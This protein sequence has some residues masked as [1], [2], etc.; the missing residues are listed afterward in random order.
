[1]N[2]ASPNWTA[3]DRIFN[4]PGTYYLTGRGLIFKILRPTGASKK[5]K[6]APGLIK[7]LSP[8]GNR[9]GK[10][11]LRYMSPRNISA[12]P[13]LRHP[14]MPPQRTPCL[15]CSAASRLTHKAALSS[16]T[17]VSEVQH[18]SFSRSE[19]TAQCP[20]GPLQ[21]ASGSLSHR[22]RGHDPAALPLTPICRGTGGPLAAGRR[23]HHPRGLQRL[24]P[25][26]G[27]GRRHGCML[28]VLAEWC[29]WVVR[30]RS[31]IS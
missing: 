4:R 1:V 25:G 23:G 19:Q 2:V 22:A 15:V 16:W 31:P 13:S 21:R 3:G 28:H 12:Q 27:C 11:S 7:K 17:R 8:S 6:P 30:G 10:P 29:E 9:G 5:K 24:L 14:L 26:H 20:A 18:C